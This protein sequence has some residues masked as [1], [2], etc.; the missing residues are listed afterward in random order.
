MAP[1]IVSITVGAMERVLSQAELVGLTNTD[2]FTFR[3]MFMAEAASRQPS[4]RFQT[5]WYTFD[6]LYQ[7]DRSASLIEFKYYLLRRTT[8]LDGTQRAFKGGAGPKN[9]SEFWRCVRKLESASLDG[10]SGRYLVLVY[11]RAYAK[12]SRYSFHKS[13]GDLGASDSVKTV[14]S[15]GVGPLEGRVLRV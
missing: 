12:R 3:S 10:I 7:D 1:W 8:D 5:E 11:E 2:E 6:L 4:A 13:Y 9:E 14:W 15:I